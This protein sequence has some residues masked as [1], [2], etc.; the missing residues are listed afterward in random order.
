MKKII[1]MYVIGLLTQLI[2]QAQ[3]VVYLSS[4]GQ[5]SSGS[6]AIGSNSWLAADFVTGNNTGGYILNSVQLGMANETGAP[7]DFTAIVYTA[8]GVAGAVPGSSLGTLNG[9]LNPVT[10]GFYT[11]TAP[12]NLTLSPSTDY[13]IVLTAGTAVANGAYEWSVTDVNSYNPNGGWHSPGGVLTS[14]NDSSCNF[15]PVVAQFALNATPITEPGALSLFGLG[16][17]FLFGS[18]FR[19]HRPRL[20]P[21]KTI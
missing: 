20:A 1:I 14:S 3:G 18:L 19:R 21:P 11:Y 10:A 5:A 12:S 13:F 6:V 17:L 15:N 9:S 16:G 7:I 8:I 2:L 4:L